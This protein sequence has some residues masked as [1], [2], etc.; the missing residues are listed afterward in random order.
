MRI[1]CHVLT[2]AKSNKV[3]RINDHTYRV[4]TTAPPVDNKANLAVAKLLAEHLG[5]KKSDVFLT[6]GHN[7]RKKLFDVVIL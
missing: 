6:A 4:S 5:V 7:T 3:T 2:Q 1:T